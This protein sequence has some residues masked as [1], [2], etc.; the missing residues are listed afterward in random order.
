MSGHE[1][2]GKPR[3]GVC[4]LG[5]F[6]HTPTPPPVGGH[7]WDQASA[8][9]ELPS[10]ALPVRSWE[11]LAMTPPAEDPRSEAPACRFL[12]SPPGCGGWRNETPPRGPALPPHGGCFLLL[13]LHHQGQ[14]YCW[15][16]FNCAVSAPVPTPRCFRKVSWAPGAQGASPEED[17][18]TRGER[19]NPAR[20]GPSFPTPPQSPGNKQEV[21]CFHS[22]SENS[23]ISSGA[24]CMA[25]QGLGP[26]GVGRKGPDGRGRL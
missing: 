26:Q 24:V 12:W 17:N 9:W 5:L 6:V 1:G 3:T 16:C 13:R 11:N 21:V 19:V 14:I 23:R 18:E 10:A 4:I 22:S 25:P 7:C 8:S 15:L 2:P 20:R